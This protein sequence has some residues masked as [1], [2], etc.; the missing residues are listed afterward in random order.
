M[1]EHGSS[2]ALGRSLWETK[3]LTDTELQAMESR[4]T[5]HLLAVKDAKQ[6]IDSHKK[7]QQNQR[8]APFAGATQPKATT[9]HTDYALKF[10]TWL[11][12]VWEPCGWCIHLRAAATGGGEG[13][14][15]PPPDLTGPYRN[16]R[17]VGRY[18]PLR[19]QGTRSATSASL[20]F[21]VFF[22]CIICRKMIGD[23]GVGGRVRQGK[24]REL[25]GI[26][27]YSDSW[28]QEVTLYLDSLF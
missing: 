10:D 4:K 24:H 16:R 15:I 6:A 5:S 17:W 1:G 26:R 8:A 14:N 23:R 9:T 20:I 19:R 13:G 21:R 7:S 22:P 27:F 28:F 2:I 18:T 12:T 25:F 11:Q 3:S